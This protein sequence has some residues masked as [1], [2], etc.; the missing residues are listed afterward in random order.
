MH[1]PKMNPEKS[2]IFKIKLLLTLLSSFVIFS[3]LTLLISKT[4][5]VQAACWCENGTVDSCRCERTGTGPVGPINEQGITL[6]C[7]TE[8]EANSFWSRTNPIC[9]TAAETIPFCAYHTGGSCDV[10]CWG[11]EWTQQRGNIPDTDT[12]GLEGWNKPI[13]NYNGFNSDPG[14]CDGI[15]KNIVICRA[16]NY[17]CG[18]K[19]RCEGGELPKTS[20]EPQDSTIIPPDWCTT[21]GGIAP[22]DPNYIPCDMISSDEY[23]TFRPYRASPCD[24]VAHEL[25]LFCGNTLNLTDGFGIEKWYNSTNLNDATYYYTDDNEDSSCWYDGT[26]QI[27]CPIGS[28]TCSNN[29]DG[30][31]TCTFIVNRDTEFW[32]DLDKA[33]LPIMGNTE[34][35]R[36][37][38]HKDYRLTDAEMA[39]E[40]VSWY[41]N[42]PKFNPAE[43]TY[44]FPHPPPLIPGGTDY[45]FPPY[46]GLDQ[47]HIVNYAG[48]LRK[49]LS[50]RNQR[51]II[52]GYKNPDGTEV[53]GTIQK[54]KKS[55]PSS[56][57]GLIIP[58]LISANIRHDQII[59]FVGALIEGFDKGRVVSF[60]SSLEKERIRLTNFFSTYLPPREEEL[61][62]FRHW[63]GS[64]KQWRGK[65]CIRLILGFEIC[66]SDPFTADYWG[67]LFWTIPFSSTEDRVGLVE[68]SDA[69]FIP[70][71]TV[72]NPADDVR[73]L[74]SDIIAEPAR[75]YFAHMQEVSELADILQSTFTAWG[76]NRV[77]PVTN[78]E[79][80]QWCDVIE[81]RSNPGDDLLAEQI[82]GN[83]VYTSEVDCKF[84]I[85]GDGRVC[86]GIGG[87]CQT[88]S[89]GSGCDINYG[90]VDCNSG[91]SCAI[92]CG[93]LPT[94]PD[95][96]SGYECV[97]NNWSCTNTLSGP[98][99]SGYQCGS[100]CS[101]PTQQAD[102][103][104]KCDAAILASLETITETPKADEVWSRLVAGEKG[105]FQ[106]LFPRVGFGAP[107]EAIRDIPASTPVEYTS[108]WLDSVGNPALGRNTPELYFPHIGGVDQYFLK[109][110][111]TALRP[112]GYGEPC[113]SGSPNLSPPDP[114]CIGPALAKYLNTLISTAEE[115][116]P[117]LHIK[118]LSP[119]F[120]MINPIGAEIAK[121]MD[122]AGTNWSKLAGIAGNAY[123]CCGNDVT[124]HVGSFLDNSGLR[125]R[126]LPVMVTET[127]KITGDLAEL[128]NEIAAIQGDSSYLGA[129]LFNAFNTNSMWSDFSL[130]DNQIRQVCN[131]NCKKVG[132]NAA[133]FYH[134]DDSFYTHADSNKPP[135]PPLS[136]QYTL[137]ISNIDDSTTQGLEM[138]L[139]HSL[140]PIIRVG[141]ANSAGPDATSYGE[142]LRELNSHIATLVA[143]R[144]YDP[145]VV[146]YAIAGPNEPQTER[147]ATPECGSFTVGPPPISGSCEPGTGFCSPSNLQKYFGQQAENA[148]RICNK[149]SGSYE[150]AANMGCLSGIF[151]D[152]SI[153]LFQINMLYHPSDASKVPPSLRQKLRAAGYDGAVTCP[154]A[155]TGPFKHCTVVDQKL[156]NIC[157]DWFFDPINNIEYAKIIYDERGNWSA[158]S[159]APLCGIQ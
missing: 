3:L 35:V 26:G 99:P 48:P 107:I 92:G 116:G 133:S 37:R 85:P 110:I 89:S 66:I 22:P 104:E 98:C 31:E 10:T 59:G 134:Q 145:S 5:S 23:H 38:Q 78:V 77:T 57:P 88:I 152:Y 62:S 129:L 158:W 6:W 122:K 137:E 120:N 67:N 68:V 103:V 80:P 11:T 109:C 20:C 83:L 27:R 49:L 124:G 86:N 15:V 140:I 63:L 58:G 42:G 125:A 153:G 121:E 21:A 154:D 12:G 2:K 119:A 118:Y 64:Y 13:T 40:Y 1:L 52:S 65:E 138:A 146:V 144:K 97:P 150:R 24:E 142:Y 71:P 18:G 84:S 128:A 72:N 115:E 149:E 123:N 28:S 19:G 73:I 90:Q 155:F 4:F 32:I 76:E 156:L 79:P 44:L 87:S 33:Y 139:D 105:V 46:Q 95:C 41:L 135:D 54:A 30:T 69:G 127:G 43:D 143:N 25:A 36:N 114:K 136:M 82:Q 51:D 34:L 56:W 126:G 39:N 157:K 100:S 53:D 55:R 75:L 148:S 131:G 106:R 101:T 93:P 61:T 96:T 91:E 159:T 16:D 151:R 45:M 111:Q 108:P 47:D 147:W 70:L 102:L 7:D 8:Y 50:H 141:T 74:T 29:G 130:D 14:R 17:C 94:D 117:L 9:G 113:L 112:Q 60:W 132:V 81:V